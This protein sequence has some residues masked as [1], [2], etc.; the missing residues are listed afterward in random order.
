MGPFFMISIIYPIYNELSLG[1]LRKNLDQFQ[2]LKENFEII[3][4]DG[5][6]KD[7]TR[8]LIL[9]RGYKVLTLSHSSRGDKL[10]F[11]FENS[12]GSLIL[13]HHPR[14]I[15]ELK[16]YKEIESLEGRCIWGGFKHKFDRD[17]PLLKFTSWY[18]NEIRFKK[19]SIIYL[20]HCFFVSR[21]LMNRIGGFPK[22]DIFE[23]T[24][25]CELL[26]EIQPPKFIDV[27]SVTSSIRFDKNGLSFQ[28]LMNQVL[29]I[30]Y[31]S[32]ASDKLMNQIY[33]RGLNLNQTYK[34]I[35][36]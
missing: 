5:G 17:H 34:K 2:Y 19:S 23:D 28:I 10:N 12:K 15:L 35:I 31:Y 4:V 21:E 29:K 25:I 24:R 6:S 18:S 8:E 7:G 13:F 27:E 20:D 11:G 30:A 14:S 36:K 33:E 16:A 26:K 32:G 3:F 1:I 9:D 22:I